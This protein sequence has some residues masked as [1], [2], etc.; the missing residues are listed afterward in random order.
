[1]TAPAFKQFTRSSVE[2]NATA[3]VT[4]S[5]VSGKRHYL[6]YISA[7]YDFAKIGRLE[8]KDGSTVILTA[9]VHN[10]QQFNFQA[11]PIVISESNA[12]SATLEASGGA[13]NEGV[14]TIHGYTDVPG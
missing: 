14:V 4:V 3:T 13:G 10:Q 9:F 7:S 12:L 1:M 8:I 2:D 6:T 5:G 11:I